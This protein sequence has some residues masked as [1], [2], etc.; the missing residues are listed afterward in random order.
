MFV[1]TTDDTSLP[2]ISQG[3][4]HTPHFHVPYVSHVPQLHF[5]LFSAGQITAYSCCFILDF[6]SYSIQDR[7]TRTLVGTG[8]RLDWLHLPPASPPAD[9]T[10]FVASASTSFA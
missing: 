7:R 6:D 3:I 1:K 9:A 10:S 8:Y 5:Q 2:V 4:L